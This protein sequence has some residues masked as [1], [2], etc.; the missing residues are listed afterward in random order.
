MKKMKLVFVAA[1]MAAMAAPA[2]KAQGTSGDVYWRIDRSVKSCSMVIDPSLTQA[3]WGTFVEQVGAITSFK[4]LASAEPLGAMKFSVG[5]DGS[6]SPVNQHDLAWINTF[7]HPD[8]DCPLGDEISVPTLR[9]RMGIT[10][11][12]DI[13][14]YW[15]T[16]PE[17]N[18]GL[19]GA[20]VK[21]RLSRESENLPATAVRGSATILTGVPDFDL[22]I[23]SVE[24]MASKRFG[25]F[26]PYVG[27]RG[28]LAVGTPTTSKV[29]LDRES[30]LVPQGYAGLSCSLWILNLAA[31]YDVANVNTFA[32]TLGV[33]F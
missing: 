25:V 27:F 15:T 6:K 33:R 11:D 12:M 9:A 13:G 21:Y 14:G 32:M 10:D 30:V 17:A 8:E 24:A 28:S 18:Y 31:E 2:A 7:V 29:N 22:N 23:Y 5:I 1:A 3:Q 20:E 19:V 4:S 16:A 26:E